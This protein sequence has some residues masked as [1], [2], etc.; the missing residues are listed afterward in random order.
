MH[1]VS[2]NVNGIRAIMK[3]EFMVSVKAMAPDILCL[4]ETKAGADEA[5][6]ALQVMKGYHVFVNSSDARKGYSGTAI[7]SKNE[8]VK[9]DL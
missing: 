3:K 8:P 1:F 9:R 7:I 5:K 4:Q 6:D 2:W